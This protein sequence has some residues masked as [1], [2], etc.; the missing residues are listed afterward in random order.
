MTMTDRNW[1]VNL[2]DSVIVEF[3]GDVYEFPER[4]ASGTITAIGDLFGEPAYRLDMIGIFLRTDV[5][6][7]VNLSQQQ[8][9]AL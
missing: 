2:G 5:R 4:T 1:T 6:S 8:G 3:R 7:L 9:P